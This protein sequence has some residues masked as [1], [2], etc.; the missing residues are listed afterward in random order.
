MSITRGARPVVFIL[1]LGL[2]LPLPVR[3]RQD[4]DLDELL[5]RVAAY[6]AAYERRVPGVVSEEDYVQRGE[7]E[8][9]T[10]TQQR[11]LRSDVAVIAVPDA[12]WVH[13]RDVYEVDGRPVRDRE[14]RLTRLFQ[15][16]GQLT[17]NEA[18]RI[19]KEGARFNLNMGRNVLVRTVNNPML[20]LRFLREANQS[21]SRF[22]LE[23]TATVDGARAAVTRFEE[24]A[25]PRLI[26]SVDDAAARGRFWIEPAS[27]RVVRS[28]L[29]LETSNPQDSTTVS[30][31]VRVRFSEA[32]D[33]GLWVPVEMNEEY[34]LS[35]PGALR[36]TGR[37]TYGNFRTFR[38]ETK[39]IVKKR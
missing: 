37:A 8:R 27:G 23:A 13:F 1:L 17:M 29:A 14:E 10:Y 12:G 38:V 5:R 6:L 39:L 18:Q 31:K 20:A 7:F 34:R 24:E 30:S 35:G 36:Y 28:E 25:L 15:T 2:A 11:R 3:S 33:A 22:R 4:P 21:R 9:S 16:P 19:V 26:G 32:E